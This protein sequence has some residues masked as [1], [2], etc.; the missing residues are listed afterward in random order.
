M[1]NDSVP[2]EVKYG[3][4]ELKI[5]VPLASCTIAAGAE[6]VYQAVTQVVERMGLDAEITPVGCM[7][8]DFIDLY[9]IEEPLAFKMSV[10]YS[11]FHSKK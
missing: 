8:L 2:E 10:F 4:K 7:V 3:K 9:L 6:E 11:Y 1:R 5:R